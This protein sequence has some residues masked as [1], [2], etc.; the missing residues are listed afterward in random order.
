[1]TY[2]LHCFK[3]NGHPFCFCNNFVSR[4]KI[5]VIFGSFVAKEICNLILLTDWKEIANALR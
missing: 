1:M 3:K 4:G 2:K 5:F